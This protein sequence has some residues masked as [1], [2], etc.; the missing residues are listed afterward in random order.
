MSVTLSNESNTLP[1]RVSKVKFKLKPFQNQEV[2]P[3][4][5]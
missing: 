3:L 2:E 1:L 4:A 5:S